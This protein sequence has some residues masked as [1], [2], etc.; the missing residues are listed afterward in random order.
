MPNF[1]EGKEK[2]VK[3]YI[4]DKITYQYWWKNE[5]RRT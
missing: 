2:N 5:D 1:K 3:G 4:W